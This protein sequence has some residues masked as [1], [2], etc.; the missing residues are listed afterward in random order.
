LVF[1]NKNSCHGFG[2]VIEDGVGVNVPALDDSW[3]ILWHIG[4]GIV[5]YLHSQTRQFSKVQFSMRVL[6]L[7]FQIQQKSLPI[8]QN[9]C[10]NLLS[11]K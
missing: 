3:W 8:A 5:F 2:P 10:A 9:S 7:D 11:R 4:G 6:I 1:T